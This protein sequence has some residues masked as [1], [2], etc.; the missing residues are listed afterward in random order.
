MS[1]MVQGSNPF[2][3][4][5]AIAYVNANPHIGF[6]LEV[7]AADVLAR[8]Q[9]LKGDDVLFLTGT[10]EHGS[11]VQRAA[12][13]AG[14]TPQVFADERAA[15]FRDHVREL[16]VSADV[17]IRTTDP[18]HIKVAQEFWKRADKSGDIYKKEYRGSYCVG[19]EAFLTESE[20]TRDG[21][22]C[23]HGTKPEQ[24]NEENYFFKLSKYTDWLRQHLLDHPSFVQP[25]GR[26]NEIMALL[27][28]GLEDVSISRP[29]NKL[30][31]GIPVPG[32]ETHVMYVL[33]DALTNYVTGAG[34][35][36]DPK[37]FEKYWP[38]QVHIV[39]QDILRFHAA[40]W[41]AMLKSAGL[42]LPHQIYSHGFVTNEGRKMSKSVGNVVDPFEIVANNGLEP[43]RYYLLAAIP[44][45]DGGDF[46]L[47]QLEQRY[48]AELANGIGNLVSRVLQMVNK[49]CQ[50]K[51]PDA[52]VD[53][54]ISKQT[55]GFFSVYDGAL[56]DLRFHDALSAL[57]KFVADANRYVDAQKPWELAKTD[58]AQLKIV[59]RTL[60]QIVY[61]V[62]LHLTPFLPET[63]EKIQGAFGKKSAEATL[64]EHRAWV[65]PDVLLL[66]KLPV[67]FPR[68][69]K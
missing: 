15:K 63:G 1:G 27:E 48:N 34:F 17:F 59:L 47:T 12:E 30:G 24:I 58:P 46:S 40:L 49:F 3:V 18:D 52:D 4:T 32:D 37:T 53:E 42:E 28:R 61:Q 60:L 35:I 50:S 64:T 56:H 14:K 19:C 10:D 11:K 45:A 54:A 55:Q 69:K 39:G 6:A 9:R 25:V 8:Y 68:R 44:F 16:G 51:V 38:A 7:L 66:E 33:F 43:T 23:I 65:I 2:Y 29:S 22:C 57:N 20:V 36:K 62:G 41:P 5:T 31:W 26:Y 67:L 21:A 13:K